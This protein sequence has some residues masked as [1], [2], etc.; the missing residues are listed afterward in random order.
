MATITTNGEPPATS[1]LGVAMTAAA[2]SGQPM[3]PIIPRDG[4]PLMHTGSLIC[5]T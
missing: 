1:A 5:E 3:L 2:Q 4:H